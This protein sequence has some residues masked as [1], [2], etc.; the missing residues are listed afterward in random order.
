M[1]KR[2]KKDEPKGTRKEKA[3]ETETSA[4]SLLFG[5][6]TN[7]VLLSFRPFLSLTE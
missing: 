4:P 5:S 6:N 2:G 1:D 7:R 3:R